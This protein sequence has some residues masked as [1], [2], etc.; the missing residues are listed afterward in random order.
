M[1]SVGESTRCNSGW[2]LHFDLSMNPMKKLTAEQFKE[3]ST[4][5][6]ATDT[7]VRQWCNLPEDR[8]FKV[9]MW[10]EERAGEV[11]VTTELHRVVRT[12]KISKSSQP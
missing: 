5:P 10:P 4:D 2:G 12:A 6:L 7:K 3:Y 11:R 1:R 9:A 8:Y